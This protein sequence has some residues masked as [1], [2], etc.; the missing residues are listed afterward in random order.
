MDPDGWRNGTAWARTSTRA[1]SPR[2][3]AKVPSHARPRSTCFASSAA[4]PI[5]PSSKPRERM[6]R[7]TSSAGSSGKSKSCTAKA[8]AYKILLSRSVTTTAA[9]IC[10]RPQRRHAGFPPW[11]SPRDEDMHGNQ[12]WQF[13]GDTAGFVLTGH[14]HT[15]VDYRE[16]Y[17]ASRL[18]PGALEFK[19]QGGITLD[20]FA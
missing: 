17:P 2:T 20:L 12:A 15:I 16:R 11:S 19:H 5:S 1:P 6:G 4:F 7:P 8:L 9:A 10:P 3:V 13:R 14:P 18:Y